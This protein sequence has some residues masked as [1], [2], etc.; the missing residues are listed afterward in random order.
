[1]T[2]LPVVYKLLRRVDTLRQLVLVLKS[3]CVRFLHQHVSG[4]T[5]SELEPVRVKGVKGASLPLS[6]S[7]GGSPVGGALGYPTLPPPW[8][9][10]RTR[11]G[12]APCDCSTTNPESG[13]R[14]RKEEVNEV[15]EEEE[16]K[17]EE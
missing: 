5:H 2:S 12:S 13:R 4:Q 14:R 10:G 15:V 17:E 16:E 11:Q 8:S 3:E 7:T 6:C 9:P 1:M